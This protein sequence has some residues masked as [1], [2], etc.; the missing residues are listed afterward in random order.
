MKTLNCPHTPPPVALT[1]AGSDSS[2]GAGIQADLKTFSA[3]GVYGASVVTAVTAQNSH[4]VT[5]VHEVPADSVAVQI[6]AV[7]GD[8]DVA[9]IK[10]GMLYSRE[11]V[12]AVA[13]ALKGS[14]IPV[15]LDPVMIATSG[16]VLLQPAAAEAM[17]ARLFPLT[18]VVTPNL[19]EAARLLGQAPALTVQQMKSQAHAV[20]AMGPGAVLLKGGHADGAVCRDLFCP[21]LGDC[22]V[23][24][25]PRQ[26]TRN[27]HGTGCT[28]SAAIAAGLAK[29]QGLDHAVRAAHGYLQGAIGA[30]DQ[31]NVGAGRGPVHHFHELWR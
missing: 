14:D 4:A 24:E 19:P 16:R 21:L 20:L 2:G 17:V 25:A 10:I 28:L 6:K 9:A 31:L 29:G 13:G 3:M 7:L 15:V 12:E 5:D 23:L 22:E 8:L 11:I 30:A 18:A 1:I 26:A 27:T